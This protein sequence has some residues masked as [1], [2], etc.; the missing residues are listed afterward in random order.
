[1]DAD[2]AV[3]WPAFSST[4]EEVEYDSRQCDAPQ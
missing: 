4:F 3:P 2:K 1:M